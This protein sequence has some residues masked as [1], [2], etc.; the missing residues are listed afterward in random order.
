MLHSA[1]LRRN[2]WKVV[3]SRQYYRR[4][5]QS[6][7]HFYSDIIYN[8]ENSSLNIPNGENTPT[9]LDYTNEISPVYNLTPLHNVTPVSEWTQSTSGMTSNRSINLTEQLRGWANTKNI[10]LCGQY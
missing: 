2:K 10:S 7:L 5:A 1:S 6:K 9:I 3:G 8:N 4:V